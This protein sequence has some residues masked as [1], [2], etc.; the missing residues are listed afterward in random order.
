MLKN[1]LTKHLGKYT[2]VQTGTENVESHEGLLGPSDRGREKHTSVPDP[3]A[4][5]LPLDILPRASS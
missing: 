3:P 2:N 5:P 1:T 4:P